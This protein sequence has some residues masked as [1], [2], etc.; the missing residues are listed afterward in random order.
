MYFVSFAG[1]IQKKY[2]VVLYKILFLNVNM[3]KKCN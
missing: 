2:N 3:R 1:N